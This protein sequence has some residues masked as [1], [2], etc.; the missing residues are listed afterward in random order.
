MYTRFTFGAAAIGFGMF[1][2]MLLFLE[3]GRHIGVRR[4]EV[5]GARSGVG[6]VDGTVYALLALLL[7]FSFNG[8]AARY[9]ERR[10]LIASE[11]TAAMTA[12]QR[13]ATLPDAT[14]P[15]V[16]QQLRAYV[17]AVIVSYREA[18]SDDTAKIGDYLAQP[19]AVTAA[20]E[21]LWAAAVATCIT[22]EGEKARMLVLP[23]LNELFVSVE[24]ELLARR[25]HPPAIIFLMLAISAFAGSVFVGYALATK[26]ARNWIYMVGVAA[27]IASAV[28]V[29]AE[30]EFPRMGLVRI[31]L[32]DRALS[33]VRAQMK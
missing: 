25:V 20:R 17:D 26:H 27:T 18:A 8:A 13:L 28:Y 14:R 23:G 31:D 32:M 2:C 1:I 4:L 10:Q 7:G 30:L 21:R 9:D 24:Q 22:P 6:V 3:I 11:A 12:W 33:D 19:A 15:Q 16:Q 5:P 29:I